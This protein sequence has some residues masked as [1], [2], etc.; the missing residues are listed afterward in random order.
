MDQGYKDKIADIIKYAALGYNRFLTISDSGNVSC[1]HGEGILVTA[2]GVSLGEVET[3]TILFVDMD[4]EIIDKVDLGSPIRT[5]PLVVKKGSIVVVTRAG[6]L[7]R[8]MGNEIKWRRK[9]EGPGTNASPCSLGHGIAVGDGSGR[10]SLYTGEGALRWQTE[11]G[12]PIQV[13]TGTEESERLVVGTEDGSLYGFDILGRPRFKIPSGGPVLGAVLYEEDAEH[14]MY[15]LRWG[16][17][18]GKAR[19]VRIK[20][21]YSVWDPTGP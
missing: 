7:F 16:S 17:R 15:Q 2:S 3:D 18:D 12:S 21:D 20:T 10:L 8:V 9:L 6:I 14:G 5:T 1:R 13:I 11:L 19:A 4:G